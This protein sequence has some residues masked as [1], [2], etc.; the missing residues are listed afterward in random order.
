MAW[1]HQKE[2]DK[3]VIDDTQPKTKGILTVLVISAVNE[4]IGQ[5]RVLS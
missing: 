4:L 5:K 1:L 3:D 2:G